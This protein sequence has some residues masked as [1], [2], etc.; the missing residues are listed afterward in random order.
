MTQEQEFIETCCDF[1]ASRKVFEILKIIVKPDAKESTTELKSA[2]KEYEVK[3]ADSNIIESCFMF[4]TNFTMKESGQ[5]S[6]LGQGKAKGS[7]LESYWGMFTYFHANTSFD[8][9]SNILANVSSKKEGRQ[10]I[11]ENDM[12]CKITD[13]LNG[14]DEKWP[15][16]HR[17]QQLL[18]TLRNLFFEHE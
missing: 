10:Y 1:G 3:A 11:I 4:L 2:T 15:N 14:R 5:Q 6:L 12:I 16:K 13:Y 17:R 18:S 8:F 9:V 7:I